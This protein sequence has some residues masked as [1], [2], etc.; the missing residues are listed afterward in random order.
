MA[1]P[2]AVCFAGAR[3]LVRVRARVLTAERSIALL[4]GAYACPGQLAP[5]H[6][7]WVC[8]L[9]AVRPRAPIETLRA[10]GFD[11]TQMATMTS[12]PAPQDRAEL[13][14]CHAEAPLR[15]I[16]YLLVYPELPDAELQR[17]AGVVRRCSRPRLRPP[18]PISRNRARW[19]FDCRSFCRS[20]RYGRKRAAMTGLSR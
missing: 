19:T 9:L 7:N 2:G 8:T 11:S 17:L 14:P 10:E 4:D 13:A 6:T 1:W 20:S 5:V 15:R 18:L 16:V 12:V 3:R